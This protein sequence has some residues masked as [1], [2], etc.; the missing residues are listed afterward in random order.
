MD[1]AKIFARSW[2]LMMSTAS[3]WEEIAD[4]QTKL[5]DSFK[6]F[7]IPWVVLCTILSFVFGMLFAD[8]KVFATGFVNAAT[9]SFSLLTGYFLTRNITLSYITTNISAEFSKINIEKLVA[10]SFTVLYVMKMVTEII[11]SLFFLKILNIYTAYI[12]WDGCA[13]LLGLDEDYRGKVMLL[14]SVCI[15]FIPGIISRIIRFMLPAF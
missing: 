8:N 7:V 2:G 13:T 12:V 14:V 1:I 11:P 3:T 10:Y 5:N 9:V 4:E 15:I 6:L